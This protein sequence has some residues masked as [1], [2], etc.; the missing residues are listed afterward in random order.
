MTATGD[1]GRMCECVNAD[2]R[3]GRC[4]ALKRRA[5][6]YIPVGGEG[7]V[8]RPGEGPEVSGTGDKR[9]RRTRGKGRIIKKKGDEHGTR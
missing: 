6:V 8:A 7:A 1:V 3:R 9:P 4:A 5:A 2:V